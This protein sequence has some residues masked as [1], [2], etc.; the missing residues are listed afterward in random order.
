MTINEIIKAF[1]RCDQLYSVCRGCPLYNK[2]H[3][4][5]QLKR[6]IIDKLNRQRDEIRKLRKQIKNYEREAELAWE[7]E[8][9]RND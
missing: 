4:R 2:D 7:R 3:C 8:V 9:M 1:E 6:A 5:D